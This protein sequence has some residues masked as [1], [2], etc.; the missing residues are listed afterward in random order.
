M[1]KLHNMDGNNATPQAHAHATAQ[2][3]DKRAFFMFYDINKAL[4]YQEYPLRKE[5][6]CQ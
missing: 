4:R 1:Q 5:Q 2:L 6:Q 3:L